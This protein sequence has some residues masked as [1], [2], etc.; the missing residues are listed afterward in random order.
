MKKDFF[1]I[2]PININLED[3]SLYP[4]HLYVFNNITKSY[5][6]Y[7]SANSP[8]TKEKKIFLIDI[9]DKGAI[10]AILRNQEKTFLNSQGIDKSQVAGLS[11]PATHDLVLKREQHLEDLKVKNKKPFHL[12]KAFKKCMNQDDFL[13]LIQKARDEVMSFKFTISHTVSLANYFA[14]HLLLEDNMQN[15]ITALSY[16]ITK[17]MGIEDPQSLA[18]IVCASYIAHIGNTQFDLELSRKPVESQTVKEQGL[19]KK[20]PGL[21][22]HLLRKSGLLISE[23]CNQVMYQHHEKH[24][25]SGYPEYKK[26]EFMEPLAVILSATTH[27]VEYSEGLI[28]GKKYLLKSI[29]HSFKTKQVLPLL[30]IEYNAL[31]EEIIGNLFKE[32]ESSEDSQESKIDEFAA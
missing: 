9:V 2:E 27:I 32:D 31:I 6:L 24:D 13:P 28:T 20:H 15:R 3:N 26:G 21:T 4:F 25:G 5:H 30:N 14:E 16:H 1:H 29:M 8:L 12:D 10:I 17:M 7:T 11:A 22:Q 19:V 18:D 23:R